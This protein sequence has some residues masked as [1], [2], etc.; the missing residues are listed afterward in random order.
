MR[1]I[2]VIIDDIF[3]PS[4]VTVASYY[5]VD[6]ARIMLGIALQV[7]L[8]V[9]EHLAGRVPVLVGSP[10]VAGR[11]SRVVQEVEQTAT[12][13]GEYDLLFRALDNGSEFGVVGLLQLLT[14]LFPCKHTHY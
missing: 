13:L 2:I 14:S 1:M 9:V 7:I 11:D 6:T 10:H 3:N 8:R 5:R 12:V 4:C